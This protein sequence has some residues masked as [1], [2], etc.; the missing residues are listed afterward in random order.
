MRVPLIRRLAGLLLPLGLAA[1]ASLS[2]RTQGHTDL[3]AWQATDLSLEQKT[4]NG[5]SGW[6]YSFAL[7]VTEE[8]GKAILFTEIETTIY[9]PGVMP[10][11][12]RFRG[13][14][15]LGTN[16]QF[17]IPLVSTIYCHSTGGG[18]CSGTQVPI[19]LW[20]IR[21]SGTDDRGQPVTTVI[22]LS[23]PPDPPA[24]PET[25]SKSV[26]EITLTPPRPG[27]TPAR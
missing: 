19:P 25:T 11:S 14:W 2:P 3:V 8:R 9:Q 6:F 15:R 26:R 4:V 22:D 20:Q 16:E 24:T 23:L 12:G 13:A 10:W 7:L 27:Q 17:R 18:M 1:C 21:M 5:R